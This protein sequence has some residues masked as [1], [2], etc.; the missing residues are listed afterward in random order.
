M[1]SKS[2]RKSLPRLA[3]VVVLLFLSLLIPVNILIQFN[4][5]HNAQMESTR[6]MFGQL[7]QAIQTNIKDIENEKQLFKNRCIRSADTVAYYV[8]YNQEAI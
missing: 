7:K 6:Q 2:I 5:R 3:T 8:E 1:Q 4:T